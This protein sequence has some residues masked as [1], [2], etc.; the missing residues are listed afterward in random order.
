METTVAPPS[1]SQ[2]LYTPSQA[3]SGPMRKFN[4]RDVF[5]LWFSLGLG[6]LAA[7]T[8]ALLVPGLSLPQALGVIVLGGVLGAA[9]LALA[10]MIGADT[11]LAAMASLRATLGD[12]GALI[13]TLANVAQLLGWGAFEVVVMGRSFD[14]LAQHHLGFSCRPGWAL[15]AGVCATLVAMLGPLSFV[16][17]FLRNWGIWLLLFA[18]L[19]LSCNALAHLD[20]HA[21]LARPAIGGL[22]FSRGIDIVV[23]IGLSWL[24][25]ISDYTRFGR[26]PASMFW[27]TFGGFGIASLWF[28][29][30]GA[31]YAAAAGA[32][33]LIPALA[34]VG[35]GLALLFI[36][37]SEID[38][39][40]ADI[41]SAAVSCALLLRWCNVRMLSG[42]FGALCIGLALG[43]PIHHFEG[44]LILIGSIFAPLFGVVLSDHFLVRHRAPASIA[45]QAPR[46][47][48]GALAAWAFGIV[49]YQTV[50]HLWPAVG[51]SLPALF[52]S[53]GSNW[54]IARYTRAACT[55]VAR[56]NTNP[57]LPG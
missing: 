50:Y 14:A 53:A 48:F 24:P 29:M 51:A 18:A 42:V 22:G 3:V 17:R 43:T 56:P 35:G 39:A 5:A 36:L 26:R 34:S 1:T 49:L 13:P 23:A 47:R 8:G 25:L 28:F 20:L 38:N 41:H 7:Q 46:W 30:L 9:L 12:H 32:N 15:A 6:L 37:M 55:A 33:A 45:G 4:G 40:F 54:I 16:R 10:G 21:L 44:F 11:G 31:I 19:W 27:G 2:S 52:A 57:P